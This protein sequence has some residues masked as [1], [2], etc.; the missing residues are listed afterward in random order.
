AGSAVPRIWSASRCSSPPTSRRTRPARCSSST[1]ASPCSRR[2]AVADSATSRPRV[3]RAGPATAL[4]DGAFL[5][6]VRVGGREVLRGVYAAVRDQN[7]DTVEPTFS[8]YQLEEGPDSFRLRFTAEHRRGEVDFVW[9]GEYLGE[10]S[11]RLTFRLDGVCRTAFR[12]NRIGFCVLHPPELAGTPYVRETPAGS[13]E[14]RFPERISPRRDVADMQALRYDV[15]PVGVSLRF[16]GDRFDM[17]DQRNWTDASFKT[18]CTP[19]A[20]P[21]PVQM[22]AGD[23]IAQTVV[24]ELSVAPGTAPAAEQRGGPD[25]AVGER[26]AGTLPPIGLGAPFDGQPIAGAA[27]ERLRALRPAHLRVELDLRRAG[28]R[29]VLRAAEADTGAL[30]A[31]LDVAL[32]ADAEGSG[33][34]EAADALRGARR[35]RR[36]VRRESMGHDRAAR[37]P[38]S[39]GRR[40][41]AARRRKPDGL[42]PAQHAGCPRPIRPPRLRHLFGQSPGPR[43]RRRVDRRDAR[44]PRRDGRERPRPGAREAR[45]RRPGHAATALQPERDRRRAVVG[46]RRT[47]T[48]RRPASGHCVR[49]GLDRRLHPPPRHGR[50]RGAHLLR[51]RRPRWRA[52]RGRRTVPGPRRLRGHRRLDRRRAAGAHAPRPAGDGGARPPAGRRAADPGRQPDARRPRGRRRAAFGPPTPRPARP[53]PGHEPR[54]VTSSRRPNLLY[55]HSD[56]HAPTVASCYG[57]PIVETPNLDALAAR[58]VT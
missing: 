15:G 50:R 40:R 14:E 4:L 44:R 38:P 45:R 6:R 51:D 35:A 31:G 16:E 22:R 19:L 23:R 46:A 39:R 57:D 55:I 28:W 43:L 24:V 20:Q 48:A 52:R 12:K 9:D 54:P 33:I 10:P 1:A 2:D 58:G 34:E 21:Y 56:Q 7:W 18:F 37:R 13:I 32:L 8:R 42:R 17:E 36:R 47:A 25:V 11:G 41:I 49:R 3:V 53:V 5:R 27:L 26:A 30:G 29:D